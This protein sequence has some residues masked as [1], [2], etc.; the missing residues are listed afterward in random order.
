MI[1]KINLAG[2]WRLSL[3]SGK[4]FSDETAISPELPNTSDTITLPGTTSAAAKGVRNTEI[5]EGYLTDEYA[6][7]G[8]AYYCR[9]FDLG[10]MNKDHIYE[11]FLERTRLTRVWVNGKLAGEYDSL[12]TP[13]IFDITEYMNSGE[14]SIC[15]AVCNCGYP[16]AGG[17]LTSSDTQSN[18]NGITGDISIVESDKSRITEI[19]AYPDIAGKAVKLRFKTKDIQDADAEIWGMSSDGKVIEKI[20]RKI[21]DSCE[22]RLDLGGDPSFW[23]EYCPVTYNIKAAVCGSYDIASV[24]FGLREIKVDG[25]E[26]KVNGET[27]QLRGKHDGLIFPLTGAAPT[28]VEEWHKYLYTVKSWG[29][30]HLRFHTCC[31]PEAA[32][33]AA[34][35]LGVYMQPELPF[36]GT[37]HGE[38]DEKFNGAEQAYLIEEGRRILRCFG[39][40][41][42]FA[43]MSLGNE[44]WGDPKRMGTIL[45][46]Y[47][48]IDNRHLYTQGSNNFQFFPNIQPEDDFFSGV[49]L[50]GERL[51]RGS[52]AQCDAPL[53]FVQTEK[54]NTVHSFDSMIFPKESSFDTEKGSDE[55]EIQYG[56]GV[57]KVHVDKKTGGLIP[58]KPIIT[59]ETGQYCSYPDFNDIPRYNGPL[60]PLNIELFRERLRAKNMLHLADKFHH[61]SGM[62]A[63]SCYKTE[64]EAAMR[65]Q[66]ISGFQLLDLQDFTGQGMAFVGMLN[67]LMEEKSFVRENDLRKKWLGFCSDCAILCEISDFVLTEGQ[68]IKV[69]VKL[70]YSG[71]GSLSGKSIKWSFGEKSG[72][73]VVPEGFRGL[74]K[75][76]EIDLTTP[77]MG[78]Y[79]LT[80][81]LDDI[82][83]ENDILP[84][85]SENSY[86]FY[87]YPVAEE[88]SLCSDEDVVIA[89]EPGQ[90]KELEG[91]G[92]RILYIPEK[93]KNSVEGFY[94]TDFWC[95]PMFRSISES[96]GKNVP[97]GTLGL[98]IDNEHPALSEFPSETYSTPRWYEI[99]SHSSCAV[100]DDLPELQPIVQTIDNF[101]RNHKLGNLFE[102]NAG[103]NKVL[104]CTCRLQE[105][106]DLPEVNAYARS[107]LNYIKS[108]RFA[109]RQNISAEALADL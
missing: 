64:I 85:N 19:T 47:H 36:W 91:R 6:F 105:C 65:S 45:A 73:I 78:T 103:A 11:L 83:G 34:D 90:L 79:P 52:Y 26:I 97:V 7:E 94:C 70:R 75:V 55:I 58:D 68:H 44:L 54:P 39:N 63:Y 21:S 4:S 33:T 32:F 23:S 77:E 14:N 84:K 30:N 74:G 57:K 72:K 20:C 29:F 96:M 76:G 104:I 53:G 62:L 40:H 5:A 66:Y 69:P 13:H 61:A 48:S 3:E 27:V 108:D 25:M 89:T 17:H 18:W 87:V 16:T 1:R 93:L 51:I 59:H 31:P 22:I 95:Y 60:K 56:T 81:T 8:V 37:L 2:E 92:V 102:V 71:I 10:E 80:L 82:R 35:M 98:L 12:C 109:P 88:H 86:N 42:S 15:V 50:S 101:E 46:E 28:T 107:L 99:V 41:P 49:R 24:T 43:M 38:N 100:L 9:N 106:M 67:G